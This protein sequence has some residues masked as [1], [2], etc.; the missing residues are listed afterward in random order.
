M[1]NILVLKNVSKNYGSFELQNIN[2]SLKENSITGFIG[3]NGAGKTTTIKAI[4]GLI[5]LD[6]GEIEYFDNPLLSTKEIK[7]KIGALDWRWFGSHVP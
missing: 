3:K 1:D 5:K 2:L 4:I 6:S 7:N